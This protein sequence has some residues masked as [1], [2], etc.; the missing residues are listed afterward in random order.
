M[1]PV[2]RLERARRA[3]LVKAY[4]DAELIEDAKNYPTRQAWR[5]AGALERLHGSYSHYGA[6]IHR[7]REFMRQCC[8]HMPHGLIG[9]KH[10]QVWSD[11]ALIASASSYAHKGDWRRALNRRD[12]AAYQAALERPEVFARAT[13]HMTPKANPYS[14]AYTVYAFEFADQHAYVG[15]TFLPK[16]RYAQHMVRGPVYAHMQVCSSFSHKTLAEGISSPA[17]VVNAEKQ[18][19]ERYA[20][21]GWTLLNT[22]T[23][24]GLGTLE[25][26]WTKELILAEAQKYQT[27]QTWIDG[28]QG[29]YRTAKREGWFEEASA[30][31]PKRDA[32]HLVGRAVSVE[33]RQKQRE[34]KL[35]QTLST[36]HRGKIADSVKEQWVERKSPQ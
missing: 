23:G 10:R 15:L 3:A 32:R 34:A 9:N 20:A 17:E 22:S 16:A 31:M 14:G 21:E 8:A 30:H 29:S 12:A 25:R 33:T 2:S 11:E 6:A 13:A 18:W 35:G 5:E 36:A 28:S 26:E 24:G 1:P 27:K 7:G 4:T 19:I